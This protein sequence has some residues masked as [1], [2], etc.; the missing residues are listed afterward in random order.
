MP[1]GDPTSSEGLKRSPRRS[2]PVAGPPSSLPKTPTAF[3]A[4][5]ASGPAR[6][7]QV[8]LVVAVV[9][10]VVVAAVFIE[11]FASSPS[12]ISAAPF[13]SARAIADEVASTHGDW[14]LIGALG[15]DLVNSTSIPLNFTAVTNCS[16]TVVVGATTGNL[17]LPSDRTDLLGG[18]A[19]VW[20]F[21]YLEP[22][23]HAELAVLVVNGAAE[24]A[25]KIS[26]ACLSSLPA[27]LLAVPSTIVDSPS[28]VAAAGAVGGRAF[29]AAH[30][31]DTSVEMGAVGSTSISGTQP[32]PVWI[33]GFSTC[34]PTALL[35]SAKTAPGA[36]FA[37]AVNGTNGQVIP[38]TEVN[39][40]CLSSLPSGL[41]GL[42]ALGKPSAPTRSAAG[43]VSPSMRPGDEA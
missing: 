31:N 32:S 36:T 25:V 5:P 26:G 28:A 14:E 8:F 43:A 15:I 1:E 23:T 11:A 18:L 33:V 29:L 38:G 12:G 10:L 34:G 30:P 22:A 21:E 7:R 19:P 17:S 4:G 6:G 42:T 24:E 35:G 41:G 2:A 3:P 20:L 37:V 40:T 9:L 27:L 16:L 13:S 39:T